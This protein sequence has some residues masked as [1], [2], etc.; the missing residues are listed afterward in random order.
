[1][2]TTLPISPDI[3]NV[4]ASIQ[5]AG[6]LRKEPGRTLFISTDATIP[7]QQRVSL[8]SSF[9]GIED[10]YATTTEPYIAGQTYFQTDPF[11]KNFIVGRWIN[12]DTNAIIL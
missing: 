1:M 7:T 10:D 4:T 12:A 11:P 6:D 5:P 3:I 9:D 8:Y 2:T